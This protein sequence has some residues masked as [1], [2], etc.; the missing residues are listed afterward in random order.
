MSNP[1]YM[2]W[3]QAAW[4]DFSSL[5]S[6]FFAS[7]L[8]NTVNF[9]GVVPSDLNVVKHYGECSTLAGTAEKTVACAGYT[10]VTGAKI[11][12]KFT[13]ANTADN[14]TLN[15]N[16][17]TAK[18]IYYHGA[19]IP[20]G[21]L[22]QNHIYEFVYDGTHYE[23]VG[24][25]DT[26]ANVA[27]QSMNGLMSASDKTKLDGIANNANNYTLPAATDNSLGGVQIGSNITNTSGTISLTGTNVTTALGYTPP[28]QDTT[29]SNATTSV[30][31]LLS[32]IDKG[33]LN[34]LVSFFN[35]KNYGECSTAAGTAAKEVAC[36][37]YSLTNGQ[38]ITVK[39][40]NTDSAGSP[41][42]NVNGTGAKA[43]YYNG[44]VAAAG[45]LQANYYHD[46]VYNGTYYELVAYYEAV[47]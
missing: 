39:F 19:A 35:I 13:V 2:R 43:I 45:K 10:L 38:Q 42:L 24:D 47:Q 29:Y 14:P 17:T 44:A 21:Y 4:N 23:L 26:T 46:F 11:A 9:D 15:V 16:S 41:T 30:A 6:A 5:F 27:T 25:I 7:A 22:A 18:A 8:G 20:A 33:K 31:G 1:S 3:T 12:V 37:G 32:A 34:A 28:K 36:T 40:T